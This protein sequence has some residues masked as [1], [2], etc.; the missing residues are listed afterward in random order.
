MIGAG[1]IRPDDVL[2]EYVRELMD[3]PDVDLTTVRVVKTPQS[4]TPQPS[5]LPNATPGTK[6][7]LPNQQN[8]GGKDGTGKEN[9]ATNTP[10]LPR[11]TP[12]PNIGTGGAGVGQTRS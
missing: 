5:T 7:Q 6:T 9:P 10:G 4:G 1:V 3:L 2:E 12:L 8:S 11:A